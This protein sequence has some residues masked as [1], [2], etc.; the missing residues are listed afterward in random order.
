MNL[1]NDL[2]QK[3]KKLH[4]SL[5]NPD[6]Y[7]PNEARQIATKCEEHGTN[8]IIVGDITVKNEKLVCDTIETIKNNIKLP[9]I[10]FLNSAESISENVDYILFMSLL[11]S[12]ESRYRG[13]VQAKCAPL[14]KKWGIKPI[15]AGYVVINTS[16]NP[17]TIERQVKLDI[18]EINDIEKAVEYALTAEMMGMSCAYFDAGFDAERPISNEMIR[19]IRENINIPILISGR[20]I[21]KQTAEEKVEAG[22]DIIINSL[23]ELINK[24]YFQIEFQRDL[25]E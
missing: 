16:N 4:F 17:T 25:N 6:K 8:A 9:I 1:I 11:N 14:V 3:Y 13:E 2:L 12:L 15:S 23:E 19:A 21:D 7:T 5:I 20:I 10:L 18:I 24:N 22:A